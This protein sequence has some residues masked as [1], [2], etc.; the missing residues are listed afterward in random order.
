MTK[1]VVFYSD[2]LKLAAVLYTP[3][4]A[5]GPW[6]GIVV[7]QG[8]GSTKEINLPAIAERLAAGGY[9]ALIFDYRGF[10]NS[11]GTR[12]RLIPEEQV[13]DI[14]AG[15]SF[16]EGEEGV[17]PK[18]LGLLG[19]SYG[20]SNAIQVAGLDERARATVAAVAFGDGERWMRGMRRLWEFWQLRDRVRKERVQRARSGEPEIVDPGEIL[21]RD[22][23]SA[24][25]QAEV[26]KKFPSRVFKLPLETAEKIIEF[27]PER[28]IPLIAPRALMLMTA[29]L[30]AIVDPEESR[31]MY[32]L[33]DEPKAFYELEGVEHHAIYV[34]E[35]LDRWMAEATGFLDLNLK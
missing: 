8:F 4:G 21:V 18:R 24:R 5:P 1:D 12:W 7:C 9:A 19:V 34:G 17:D 16:L 28:F 23:E 35:A 15:L 2:G 22:P 27:H 3:E 32:R 10:G 13:N 14:R 29:S 33:A 11:E 20:G 6:P 26:V 31:R 25:W 30:D